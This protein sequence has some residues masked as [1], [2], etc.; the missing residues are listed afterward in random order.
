[1]RILLLHSDFIEYQPISK[2]VEAA[3]DIQ[4]KASKKI[5]E[6]IVALI[7]VEKDDDESIIDDVCKELKA[8]SEKKNVRI[9]YSILMHT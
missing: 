8:Y 6:V 3:E 9:Y 4:Y 2:E 1:M 7:A 5:D